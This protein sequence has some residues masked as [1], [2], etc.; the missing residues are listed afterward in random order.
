[1]RNLT[2]LPLFFIQLFAEGGGTGEGG[3]GQTGAAFAQPQ[4]SGAK[5]D[6]ASV[7]YGVQDD[8]SDAGE[9]K[10]TYDR[11]AE[12]DALIKGDYKAEFENRVKDIVTRRLKGNEAIVSEYNA[13]KPSL[14]LLYEKY[15]VDIGDIEG[16]NAAVED[17][18]SIY[19]EEALESGLT[20]KQVR[21]IRKMKR[22]NAELRAQMEQQAT[23]QQADEIYASW[24]AQAEKVKQLYDGF[25][26]KAE[27]QNEQFR[28]LLKSNIPVQTAFEVVHRDEILPAAMQ[29]SAKKAAT[30]VADSV[31]AGRSRP[32]EGAMGSSSAAIVKSDVSTLTDADLKEIN[33]RV[34]R[35]ERIRF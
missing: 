13:L 14:E 2:L 15:G 30:K 11:S 7:Q 32:A 26:L 23:R 33:E 5:G 10:Q 19:E 1:M 28:T 27:L 34:M 6:L 8:A 25:D 29:Y 20:T 18:E 3:A 22:E 21:E 31:R 35:G 16:F 17:D 4:E 9:Q 24:M 12:F